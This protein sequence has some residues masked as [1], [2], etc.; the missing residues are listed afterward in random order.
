M[1]VIITNGSAVGSKLF[2]NRNHRLTNICHARGHSVRSTTYLFKDRLQPTESSRKRT[3][4]YAS[5]FDLK[6]CFSIV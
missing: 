6:Y 1:G 4:I 5:F 2:D 3:G